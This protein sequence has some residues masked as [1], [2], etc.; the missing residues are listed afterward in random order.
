LE[1]KP[2]ILV[3]DDDETN[4]G[5]IKQILEKIN[6]QVIEAFNGEE[7]LTK[8][9]EDSPDLLILDVIM[10]KMNGLEVCRRIKSS[11]KTR[12]I[13]VVMLTAKA[14]IEDKVTGFELGA[15]DYISKPFNT[16]EFMARIKGLVDQYFYRHK[17]AEAETLEA[18]EKMVEG[19][20]HEV[21]NPIVTIGGF[22]RRIRDRNTD[23]ESLRIYAD[24]II[25]EV[26]RL[27]TMVDAIVKLKT[28]IVT[29]HSYID[30]KKLVDHALDHFRPIFEKGTLTV[31]K[32]YAVDVMPIRG[33]RKNLL[34]ALVH[35]I[36]NALEAM[37]DSGTLTIKIRQEKEQVVINVIDSGK[38]IPK[39]EISQLVRPFYTSKLSGA[40]IGLTTVN[41]I[42][43]LHNG[44]LSI[45]SV[46]GKGTQVELVLPLEE[47]DLNNQHKNIMP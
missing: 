29:K 3:V 34:I 45:T 23:Q 42:I 5:L 21:R 15:D 12:L 8:I 36:E 19:V 40:G 20:A 11:E 2:K 6:Y 31:N 44:Q 30:V 28:I 39:S 33:D 22:A 35:V 27:E 7:A 43:G 25:H 41:H 10:P 14:L 16:K 4:V 32:E 26:E 38:G 46:Q 37:D 9:E 1:N 47:N 17:R 24:H 18:L 13:P